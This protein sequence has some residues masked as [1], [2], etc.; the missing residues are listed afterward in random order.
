MITRLDD[1]GGLLLQLT[2]IMALMML[3][4][5]RYYRNGDVSALQVPNLLKKL[6]EEVQDKMERAF[7][8]FSNPSQPPP[9]LPP[10]VAPPPPFS[11]SPLSSP[12]LPLS[13]PP[14][15]PLSLYP[16]S[17]FPTPLSLCLTPRTSP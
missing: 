9:L 5:L 4:V 7:L 2:F 16:S 6:L 3:L 10:T 17:S 11:L 8:V 1:V 15:L 13:L 14:H 12:F